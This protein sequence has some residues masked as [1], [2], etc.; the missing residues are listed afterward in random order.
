MYKILSHKWVRFHHKKRVFLTLLIFFT[1]YLAEAQNVVTGKVTTAEDGQS[2]PGVNITVVN[3]SSG[4]TTDIDGNFSLEVPDDASLKFSF[5]GFT[6]RTISVSSRSVINVALEEDIAQLGEVVVIGY[7]TQ[8]RGDVNGSVASIDANVIENIPQ[9]SLDQ[10]MQGRAAGVTVTQNS[11]QPGAAV[12]VR[13]RGI[14]SITGSNEPLYVIDGVP[15]SGDATNSA[16]SGRTAASSFNG[17]GQTGVSPLA[18]INPNDIASLDILKDAS[19]TAIYGSRGANG[20]VII[21]TKRGQRGETGKITYSNYFAI[22]EPQKLID[23]MDLPAYAKLQNDLAG[24]YGVQPRV[25]FINI[26]LLGE[27][28]NWQNEV[29]K[30]AFMQNHEVSLSGSKDNVNYF[31]SG[32]YTDQDGIVIGSNFNRISLR[33]NVDAKLKE[34]FKVGIS[35]T[36]SQTDE[37]ITLNSNRNGIVS[38]GLLQAPDVAVRNPDGSF[39]GPP[40]NPSAVEGNINPVA[41]ALSRTNTLVRSRVL[42]NF[43]AELQLMDGLSFKTEIGGD[44]GFDEN[45]LFTPTYEWGRF[46]NDNATLYQSNANNTFW[47][48]KNYFTYKKAFS[49]KNDITLLVGQ[50]AQQSSWEGR[51]LIGQG[52]VSNDIQTMNNASTLINAD[53]YKGS[54][55]LSS[56]YARVLYD[57]DNRY[58]VTA[59]VRADG[60]SKFDP[61]GDTQWGVFPSFSASWKVFNENF[62]EGVNKDIFSNLRLIAGYGVV[63]N[64]GIPNYLYGASLADV[65][66]GLGQGY[67]VTN[68]PN[69]DL[70]WEESYQTNIGLNFSLFK[71]S[72]SFNIEVYDKTSKD[73]LYQ[74]PLPLYLTGPSGGESYLAGVGSPYVNLGELQ[75]RGIDLS[76]NY[77]LVSENS[78]FSWSS[79]L[80]LSHYK[81]KVIDL[82]GDNFDIT[83]TITTG[84]LSSPLT[85]TI[86]GQP[87]GLYYGY[88]VKGIFNDETAFED[89][90]VQFDT[91]FSEE[92]GGIWLGDIQYED[93]NDDGVINEDDRTFIGNPHPDFTFGF[94]NNFRY[95]NFDLTIFLQGSYGN[96]VLNL[97]RKETSSLSRL[98]N[99]QL[100]ES[101]DYWTEENTDAKYPR[102]KRGDDN[103]NLFIS[104]RYVEDG[105]YL[106]VQN[107]KLG[108]TLNQDLTQRV[109]INRL[110]VF[111]S[112][113]NLHTFTNYTGYDPEIGAFN[114]DALQMGVDIG[115]YPIPRTFTVGINAEF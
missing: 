44:F 17:N 26:E 74:L 80:N 110:K 69:P 18:A 99:N 71:E 92:L 77:S 30:R 96:D 12:S 36:A 95:K 105:S 115:R 87:I 55:A 103:S 64:Q 13:V 79:N 51:S 58:G 2:L 37:N 76:I 28:T 70:K 22:Q 45:N 94:S 20:V 101:S 49:Q 104:D 67:Y 106:R 41:Q 86:E 56:Y 111:A 102:P 16:T 43:Y 84:F 61:L 59:T 85:R 7:G 40:P 39:A 46:I 83:R 90:P 5:I 93:V 60:S 48:I 38:L 19:A 54:Q 89:L 4:T 107:I 52:F 10:L 34:W 82:Y 25:E 91:P 47:I 68:I 98:Y 11:G 9:P 27:G 53:A 24:I 66:T 31:I 6:T 42:G 100:E 35:L 57:F 73:F 14:T 75:N 50:E 97:T 15:V 1:A 32:G 3:G 113:Q 78:D 21:T 33:S 72:L 8:Q 23:V 81:N 63:G 29:F 109:R 65:R 88:K 62:M 114:Q 112:I 108:Y